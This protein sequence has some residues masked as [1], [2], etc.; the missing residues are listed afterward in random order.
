MMSFKVQPN[1]RKSIDVPSTDPLLEESSRF[2][3]ELVPSPIQ[4]SPLHAMSPHSPAL[5]VLQHSSNEELVGW[6]DTPYLEN[7][8]SNTI[9]NKFRIQVKIDNM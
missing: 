9:T 1:V 4:A 3:K 7:R 2:N 6:N 5:S 8:N